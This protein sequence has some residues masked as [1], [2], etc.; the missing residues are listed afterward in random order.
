MYHSLEQDSLNWAMNKNFEVATCT[1]EELRPS[2]L[3][4]ANELAQE[5]HRAK[6]DEQYS[7]RTTNLSAHR[8]S[9]G[10]IVAGLLDAQCPVGLLLD[11]LR[12][13]NTT[14]TVTRVLLQWAW[15]MLDSILGKYWSLEL[16]SYFA[17]V[18][19]VHFQLPVRGH[20]RQ[21]DASTLLRDILTLTQ[22]T[23]DVATINLKYCRQLQSSEASL[24]LYGAMKKLLHVFVL[25]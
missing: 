6:F 19:E 16:D 5:L 14:P 4:A 18:R 9:L 1:R 10:R 7:F 22:Y 13:L 3:H 11:L 12:S 24:R 17:A 23:A 21:D 20:S 8:G 2:L 25:L 15:D